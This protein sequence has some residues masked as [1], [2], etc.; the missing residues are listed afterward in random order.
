MK[1]TRG[2]RKGSIT[3]FVIAILSRATVA[4]DDAIV[5]EVRAKHRG[6]K[7][8]KSHLAWYKSKFRVGGLTGMFGPIRRK[9]RPSRKRRLA[10]FV[11]R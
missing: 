9:Q 6:S 5:G 11:R 3:A 8:K 7:F 1:K 4:S 10:A 2:P